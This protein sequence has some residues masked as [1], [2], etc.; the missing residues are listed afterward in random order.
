MEATKLRY[1][2]VKSTLPLVPYPPHATRQPITTL[3]LTLRPLDHSDL[4]AFFAM[5]SNPSIMTFTAQG[6]PDADLA[7]TEKV[8]AQ[9]LPPHDA[10]TYVLA[11]CE[12]AT[13]RFVGIGG[14]LARD[15]ELGWPG[16]G[17]ALTP[18]VWGRGYATEFLGA[19]MGVWW[20]LERRE[21]DVK[22]E[23]M[24][25]AGL[26]REVGERGEVE[27]MAVAIVQDRNAASARV[28]GKVGFRKVAEWVAE[29]RDGSGLETVFVFVCPRPA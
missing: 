22:V 7:A 13:G 1:V 12:R 10:D 5:R 14:C 3:R 4:P 18:E 29:R 24:S 23:A 28:L 19:F 6:V 17:Y 21:G 26:G 27:E 20:G 8:L 16:I 2:T 15:G 25:L 11:I 9:Y